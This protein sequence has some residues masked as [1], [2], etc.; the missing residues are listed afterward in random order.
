MEN[1]TVKKPKVS[2][3]VVG[4][5]YRGTPPLYAVL[6]TRT[7]RVHG[8]PRTAT[9]APTSLTFSDRLLR[10]AGPSKR[11]TPSSIISRRTRPKP[12]ASF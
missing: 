3:A 5:G 11:F 7:G 1:E 2:V 4:V 10:N 8:K 9:P 12:F 6:D